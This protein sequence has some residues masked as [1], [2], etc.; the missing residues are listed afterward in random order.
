LRFQKGKVATFKTNLRFP[1][2]NKLEF[3]SI[4][5]KESTTYNHRKESL[6]EMNNPPLHDNK[7]VRVSAACAG[8]SHQQ[9]PAY[10]SSDLLQRGRRER[11][12][13]LSTG[14]HET[15]CA[16]TL[17]ASAGRATTCLFLFSE[18]LS[19]TVQGPPAC[20]LCIGIVLSSISFSD[21]SDVLFVS[22]SPLPLPPKP[23]MVRK[24]YN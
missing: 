15:S 17:L 21:L 10:Y 12:Q 22:V 20:V 14:L 3:A 24:L 9:Y 18:Y 11:R 16:T 8:G 6:L 13:V 4:F 23:Y 7:L 19:S 1:P 2:I 5:S